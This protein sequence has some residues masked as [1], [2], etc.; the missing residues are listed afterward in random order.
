MGFTNYQ[1]VAFNPEMIQVLDGTISTGQIRV[2][3][4]VQCMFCGVVPALLLFTARSRV[5]DLVF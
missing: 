4:R 1:N 5:C 2:S 3:A